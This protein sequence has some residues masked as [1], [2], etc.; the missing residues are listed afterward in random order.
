MAAREAG[1]HRATNLGGDTAHRL[2]IGWRG[3]RESGFDDVHAKQIEL[4]GQEQLLRHP[5][6]EPRRLLAVTQRRIENSNLL[7]HREVPPTPTGSQPRRSLWRR[8]GSDGISAYCLPVDV[9]RKD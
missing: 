9:T 4:A 1:D 3:N 8:R 7:S 2:G 6:R 5:E